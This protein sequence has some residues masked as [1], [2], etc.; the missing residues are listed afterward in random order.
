MN[1][2]LDIRHHDLGLIQYCKTDLTFQHWRLISILSPSL[3]TTWEGLQTVIL[4]NPKE[5]KVP[6]SR[7]CIH[8]SQIQPLTSKEK[9][10]Q[11][12][13]KDALWAHQDILMDFDFKSFK[14]IQCSDFSTFLFRTCNANDS[15]FYFSL[16]PIAKYLPRIS[17]P[18]YTWLLYISNSNLLPK[19]DYSI[20]IT[21]NY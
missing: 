15:G 8:H 17:F 10:G 20:K 3:V 12:Q 9:W 11:A 19:A 18:S 5:I 6:Q 13:W 21:P 16:T 1:I 4:D 2:L 7:S 14:N